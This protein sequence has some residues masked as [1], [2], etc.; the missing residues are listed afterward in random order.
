[1]T[2]PPPSPDPVL[3]PPSPPSRL[4]FTPTPPF[5][6]SHLLTSPTPPL[7]IAHSNL[8]PGTRAQPCER[9][10]PVHATSSAAEYAS[11][12]E[13]A[14]SAGAPAAPAPDACEGRV[15]VGGVGGGG[16]HGGMAVA[17]RCTGVAGG[18]DERKRGWDGVEAHVECETEDSLGLEI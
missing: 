11:S 16:W 17:V 12:V 8:G 15:G 10:K 4:P 2:F 1:M 14:Q 7:G 5:P 13:P 9:V 3:F 18:G 6:P